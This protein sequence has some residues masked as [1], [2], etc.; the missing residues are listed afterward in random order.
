M[1]H[2]STLHNDL[3]SAAESIIAMGTLPDET[4]KLCKQ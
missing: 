1:A 4:K 3:D 2:Y